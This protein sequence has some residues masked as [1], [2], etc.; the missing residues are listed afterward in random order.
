M[1][2]KCYTVFFDTKVME[3]SRVGLSVSK[4][5][6]N[7]PERNRIKRQLRMMFIENYDFENMP[8]DLIVIVKKDYLNN[9]YADNLSDLEKL[10]K[11]VYNK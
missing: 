10:I 2:S 8:N 7:S 5:L 3:Y 9:S 1:S 4:K 6:G 11:K